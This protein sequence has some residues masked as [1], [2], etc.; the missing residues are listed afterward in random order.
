MELVRPGYPLDARERVENYSSAS[1][2]ITL[3][4]SDFRPASVIWHQGRFE[5]KGPQ[6][7]QDEVKGPLTSYVAVPVG[8]HREH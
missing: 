8:W 2:G 1:S 7:S 3:L 4:M 5:V 6:H